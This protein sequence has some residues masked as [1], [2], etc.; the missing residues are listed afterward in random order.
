M[1]DI[2][3]KDLLDLAT[4]ETAN[5]QE[6]IQ[7]MYKWHFERGVTASKLVLGS[8]ASLLAGLLLALLRDD[9]TLVPWQL[10]LAFSGVA[11]T[12]MYGVFRFYRTRRI[13]AEFIASLVLLRQIRP[14]TRFVELY[15]STRSH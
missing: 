8:G 10:A 13:H 2:R 14:L 1:K 15:R 3:L 11:V 5:P 6:E 7:Q 4:A 12:L 9:L